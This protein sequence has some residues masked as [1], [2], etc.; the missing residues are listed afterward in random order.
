MK[1]SRLLEW[2]FHSTLTPCW[3]CWRV[4]ESD[5]Y[6]HPSWLQEVAVKLKDLLLHIFSCPLPRGG[7]SSRPSGQTCVSTTKW[8]CLLETLPQQPTLSIRSF[9]HQVFV[10]AESEASSQV[11][12]RQP[13]AT[14]RKPQLSWVLRCVLI[15]VGFFWI[16]LTSH[17][18]GFQLPLASD[19]SDCSHPNQLSCFL[20]AS[21]LECVTAFVTTFAHFSFPLGSLTQLGLA[22][23][24][25]KAQRLLDFGWAAKG[26]LIIYSNFEHFLKLRFL[27]LR[28]HCGWWLLPWN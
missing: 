22:S 26:S 4:I 28:Y 19:S 12:G 6:W 21:F 5:P 2:R 11:P 14:H 13:W 17:C 8:T 10:S 27:G 3:G 18:M 15:L 24:T 7:H 20:W 16:M 25:W 9:L 23:L 1:N